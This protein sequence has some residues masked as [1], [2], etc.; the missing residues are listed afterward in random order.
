MAN[1]ASMSIITVTLVI[2][3]I[4]AG[5]TAILVLKS[6]VNEEK[7]VLFPG[8]IGDTALQNNETGIYS[9]ESI[10]SYDNFKGDA[11]QGYK[12]NYSGQNGTVLIF[13]ARM[14]DNKSATEAFEDMIAILGYDENITVDDNASIIGSPI[15]LP[16][17]NPEVFIIQKSNNTIWHYTFVKEND[18]YW[19]GFEEPSLQYQIDMLIEI[20]RYTNEK[21]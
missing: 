15:K 16:V 1:N 7:R 5:V 2:I 9:I 11:I 13:I 14:L 21:K 6:D 3:T 8:I 18:V 19:I 4:V 20:Y 12:A 10:M 17:E